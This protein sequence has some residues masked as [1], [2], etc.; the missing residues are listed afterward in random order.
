M[1][2]MCTSG[3]QPNTFSLNK[4]LRRFCICI[5]QHLQTLFKY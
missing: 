4:T 5:I 3:S 1:K 2:K